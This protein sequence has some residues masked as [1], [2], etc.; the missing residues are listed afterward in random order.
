MNIDA[1]TQQAHTCCRNG[2]LHAARHL[3]QQALAVQPRNFH[4][5]NL[6]GIIFAQLG[7]PQ[8]ASQWFAAAI[9]V[10]GKNPIAHNNLGNA[11]FEMR[12]YENA[13]AS[14][15]SAIALDATYADAHYNRANALYELACYEAATA[16]YDA[17]IALD[18]SNAKAYNN[19]GNALCEQWRYHAA[20]ASYN[21]AITLDGRFADAHYNRAN[22]LCDL[23]LF[24]EAITGY[25]EAITLD[26]QLA[27]VYGMR[28]HAK[29]Q[30]CDWSAFDAEIKAITEKLENRQA[31]L[32]PFSMLALPCSLR[33]QQQIAQTWMG[34]KGLS[35]GDR[36]RQITVGARHNKIRLGYFSADFRNHPLSA[37]TAEMFEI[38]DRTKFEVIA[39]SLGPRVHDEM[40]SRLEASFDKFLN[41]QSA[42]SRDI[43]EQARSI[44][45][46]VAVDLGGYTRG[47][48]PE[49]FSMRCAPVQVSY[50]GY[51]GTTAA[52]YMD[53]MIADKI[54]IPAAHRQYYTEKI[55]YLPSYQVSDSTRRIAPK[56]FSRREFGLPPNA[57]VFCCFNAAYKI[58]PTTF[59]GWM[60]ILKAVPD[61][62]LFLYA[63]TRAVE[64]NLRQE[65]RNNGVCP[66]RLIFGVW[67]P[68]GEYLARYRVADLFLDTLPYNAG[69]TANDA[70]W[71]GLPV[72]TCLG[73]TFAGRVAASL[74]MA[75]Q[76]PELITFNQEQYEHLAVELATNPDR[77]KNIKVRIEQ[78]RLTTTLF[79]TRSFTK[80]IETAFKKMLELYFAGQHAEHIY[81]ESI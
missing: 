34:R 41:L 17:A 39:F 62:V 6:L 72:L 63:N 80:H 50:L 38:H 24:E 42:S 45:I 9:S 15:D 76:L 19:R 77:L 33:L 54:T 60:R 70:L 26:P 16:S 43:V 5:L 2:Q 14:F 28:L 75:L 44:G 21:K 11:L 69:T 68:V 1:L 18:E 7:Q 66:E 40:R 52:P 73:D 12:R 81:V 55:V 48:R 78:N 57:F 37:L 29:M 22:A 56:N 74:L 67:L 36:S 31:A 8:E 10:N 71:V 3:C 79:D 61:A 51:L 46:D 53:Y 4:A 27:F 35:N 13:I 30:I 49:I 65:A 58:T 32:D 25:D 23:K 59:A 64:K 20:V 47:S